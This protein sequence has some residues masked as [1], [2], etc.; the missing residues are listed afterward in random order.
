MP[1]RHT[2]SEQMVGDTLK[3]PLTFTNGTTHL[4]VAKDNCTVTMTVKEDPADAD[5][6]AVFQHSVVVP[7]NDPDALNGI[8]DFKVPASKTS[9]IEPGQ[10]FYD[11]QIV[12]PD[13][14]EDTVETILYG[15]V[16]MISQI[17][18]L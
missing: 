10:Y 9:G 14:P 12:T 8:I 16:R 17:T 5:V 1:T 3:I 4:P 6:D 13:V 15:T 11:I 2:L 7:E 18:Q